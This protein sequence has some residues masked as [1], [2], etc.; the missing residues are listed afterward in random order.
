METIGTYLLDLALTVALGLFIKYA[1]PYIK[2]RI[3]MENLS[4]VKTWVDSL[5]A[6][7]EQTITG[8]KMGTVKKMWVISSL[9]KLEIVVDDTVD[10]LIESAVHAINLSVDVMKEVVVTGVEE[11]TKGA[12]TEEKAKKAIETVTATTEKI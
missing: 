10:A 6:A 4:F 7:A 11:A 12:V 8:S 1:V 2:S 5:V 3:T 9:E